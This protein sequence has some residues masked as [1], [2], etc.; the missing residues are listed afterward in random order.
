MVQFGDSKSPIVGEK[1][2]LKEDFL[3]MGVLNRN[4][5][6]VEI[7]NVI[8]LNLGKLVL[9]GRTSDNIRFTAKGQRGTGVATIVS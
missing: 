8:F 5:L 1:I 9:E 7:T 4:C 3:I 6:F 2:S